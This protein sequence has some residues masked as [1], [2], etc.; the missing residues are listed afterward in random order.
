MKYDYLI[1][2]CGIAGA[3]LAHRLRKSGKSV[4]IIDDD[5]PNASSKVAAGFVNP[6]TGRRIV[7]S[8]MADTV[9]PHAFHFYRE[10]EGEFGGIFF[11]KV[12]ALELVSSVH[13]QNEW[14]RRADEQEIRQYFSS[15]SVPE[16]LYKPVI[17]EFKKLMRITQSG[18]LNMPALINAIC[19][20]I[21]D[22]CCLEKRSFNE[23]ELIRSNTNLE[24]EGKSFSKVIFTE[25][26]S[27]NKSTL[28]NFIPMVPAK[29]EIMTIEVP[30][31]PQ[32]F[33]LL[34]GMFFVP[35]GNHRFRCGATYSWNF[36]NAQPTEEGKQKLTEMIRENLKVPFKIIH[37]TAG[38]RPT[39]KDRRPV[40]GA[41]PDDNR[42][43][44]FNG[45]GTKGAMLSPYFTDLFCQWLN[46]KVALI[47]ETDIRRFLK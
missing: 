45:L 5:N 46:N 40:M 31:L 17:R 15:D 9:L 12:D 10:L 33:I 32:D 6:I 20:N 43:L 35:I 3:I 18:W 7:K 8:W 16:A 2:G 26:Y 47:P 24:Y 38:V 29:G 42:L 23:K 36:E 37:H 25:G 4:Y 11:H 1:V 44:I 41:H 34:C 13:E 39:M 30:E 21:D 22:E 28:W 19:R 14:T 27:V